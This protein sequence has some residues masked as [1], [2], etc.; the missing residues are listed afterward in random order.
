MK[1]RNPEVSAEPDEEQ[2]PVDRRALLMRGGAV[3]VGAAGAVAAGVAVAAP[4]GAAVS[5]PVLQ[6]EVNNVGT[7]VAATEITA[8]NAPATPTPTLVLTNTGGDTSSTEASPNLRLT[9]AAS[10]LVL[11]SSATVGGDLLAGGDGLLWFTHAIP[12]VGPVAATVHTDATDNLF[13][14]L[15]APNRILDTRNS[16]GRASILDAS[17]NLNSSG[18]LIG[19]KTIHVNL[20]SL[21]N[22]GDAVTANL[23]VTQPTGV[24]FITVW[25][26]AV[27][28][29]N[30]SVVDYAA[31]QT[32]SNLT[33][34]GLA[35]FSSAA[36]DTIAIFA[37][38]TTHLILDVA[39]FAVSNFGQVNPKFLLS[40]VTPAARAQRARQALTRPR[41][42]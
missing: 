27:A 7:N 40:A 3:A 34:T 31:N 9:P 39:G 37:N 10:A 14:P 24:G 36:T 20:T 6:G 26:G 2:R 18:M 19:G 33:V 29:P 25:S 13:A 1:R 8:D 11:P 28:R 22:F 21:V 42:F 15:S 16:A 12:N 5:D 30:T 38:V 41:K 17:G 4:A 23:T 35:E 32:I